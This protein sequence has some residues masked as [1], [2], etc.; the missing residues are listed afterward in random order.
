M[1]KYAFLKRGAND[2]DESF[3]CCGKVE[4]LAREAYF[5]SNHA[6]SV[7]TI[8]P[9]TGLYSLTEETSTP[10]ESTMQQ[11]TSRSASTRPYY[12]PPP[13]MRPLY[14]KS[15]PVESEMHQSTS[16][17]ASTRPYYLPPP[18]IRPLYSKSVGNLNSVDQERKK[19]HRKS[20]FPDRI[21]AE[22]RFEDCSK[23]VTKQSPV[24]ESPPNSPTTP[25]RKKTTGLCMQS[26]GNFFKRTPKQPP[27]TPKKGSSRKN[28]TPMLSFSSKSSGSASSC[29]TPTSPTPT[30]ARP[31]TPTSIGA[32]PYSPETS[33]ARRRLAICMGIPRRKNLDPTDVD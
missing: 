28:N 25:S 20:S 24:V 15:T 12:L 11:S 8:K 29:S 4:D 5:F 31:T 14:S 9:A 7:E 18:P 17:S 32:S 22:E 26:I 2:S 27:S 21:L 33:Q 1:G 16:H 30:S 13:P 3:H 23:A 10:V 6:G 19:A